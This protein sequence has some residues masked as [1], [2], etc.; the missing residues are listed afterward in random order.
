MFICCNSNAVLN[1]CCIVVNDFTVAKLSCVQLLAKQ[2]G[3][4]IETE[5][6]LED[7][8][9]RIGQLEKQNKQ[10]KEKVC[11]DVV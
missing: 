1:S 4:D 10:Y 6:M 8:H 9:T 5:E 3:R 7:L 2:G 11:V